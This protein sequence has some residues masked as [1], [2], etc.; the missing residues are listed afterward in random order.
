MAGNPFMTPEALRW[1]NYCV[2]DTD[3]HL[4]RQDAEPSRLTAFVHHAVLSHARNPL[5]TCLGARSAIH[6]GSYRFG[7]YPSLGETGA[8]A[9][10]AHDLFSFLEDEPTLGGRFSTYIASFE[11]P[12]TAD[13]RTFEHLLWRALQQLHDADAPLH[14]WDDTVSGDVADPRFSFSFAGTALFVVGLHAGSSRVTRRLAWPTLVFNP[15]R[16]FESLK[17]QGR[18]GRLRDLIRSAERDLQGGINPMV[19]DFG[20]RSEAGQYS[21]RAVEEGWQCPFVRRREPHQKQS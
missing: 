16:Q 7:L 18:Y 8:T 6:Q 17:A 1:S 21:G 9:A 2:P 14:P 12:S 3:G 4:T 15:H 5:F 20:G 13:E 19:E 11:R 10:L